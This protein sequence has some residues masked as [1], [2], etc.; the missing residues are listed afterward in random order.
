[1]KVKVEASDLIIASEAISNIQ[2]SVSRAP[3]YDSKR[4]QFYGKTALDVS[5]V[6]SDI[7][8]IASVAQA[9]ATAKFILASLKHSQFIANRAAEL[10]VPLFN[11]K[12][13]VEIKHAGL[14]SQWTVGNV[15]SFISVDSSVIERIGS[16]LLRQVTDSEKRDFGFGDSYLVFAPTDERYST[17]FVGNPTNSI[18]SRALWLAKRDAFMSSFY[19]VSSID[20]TIKDGVPLLYIYRS[21]SMDDLPAKS[22]K[23]IVDGISKILSFKA[24]YTK[25]ADYRATVLR[26][27]GKWVS[28]E[29]TIRRNLASRKFADFWQR[30][31]DSKPAPDSATAHGDWAT[32]PLKSAGKESSR[33]WGIE[34]ETVRADSTSR[35]AGWES[36]YDGSLPDGDVD[37]SCDCD[38]CND[39]DHCNDSDYSCYESGEVSYSSREFVSPILSHFNSDGLR[40]L[41]NDLGTDPNEDYRPGIHVHVGASDLS[42]IDVARLLVAYS[43]VERIMEPLLHRK[44]RNYCK[45]TSTDQLRWWLGKLRE[46]SKRNPDTIPTP[47]DL[48]YHNSGGTPDGRYVDV[49][50]QAL[51]QHGTIEFRSMGA[52]YDYAHLVRWAWFAREMVNVSKLGIDQREWTACQSVA[53]VVTLLRKYGSEL[54]S[55]E[56]FN[57]YSAD[58]KLS[59]EYQSE[60]VGA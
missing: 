51:T 36:K 47:Q 17:S 2:Y 25:L 30:M 4:V 14:V 9:E 31:K 22:F 41:C 55:N 23:G 37:C 48:L 50:L 44:E 52:W 28:T 58:D 57:D 16:D 43:A 8:Y 33:T 26:E 6:K 45:P 12:D 7:Y 27:Q 10:F 38:N 54:P 56:L 34:I 59:E 13:T 49:N 5:S 21:N 53:D 35:P 19:G 60:L 18:I 40:K 32:I 29:E 42:V 20:T 3:M 11:G 24:D 46:Y 1:M 15:D 39:N